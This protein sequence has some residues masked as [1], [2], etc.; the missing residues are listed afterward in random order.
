MLNFDANIL[1]L[2]VMI[3]NF[4]TNILTLIVIFEII[5][6]DRRPVQDDH[7]LNIVWI[8]QT[9]NMK[10]HQCFKNCHDSFERT[11]KNAEFGLCPT[12]QFLNQS[13]LFHGS[14]FWQQKI[15]GL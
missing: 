13:Q 6:N 3:L 5:L 11:D 12:A 4:D 14:K 1:T 9:Q 8:L 15:L 10:T 7:C 2:I